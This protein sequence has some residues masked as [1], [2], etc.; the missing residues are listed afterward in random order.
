MLELIRKIIPENFFLRIWWHRLVGLMAAIKYGFPAKNLEVIGVTGTDGKS[1]TVEFLV[2]ILEEK[3]LKVGVASTIRFQVGDKKWDN[4]THKTTMGR[5]ALQKL[6]KEMKKEKC[7]VVVLEV[8]S[9]ALIQGRLIGIPFVSAVCTNL[10]PEHLD[11]HKNMK[12]YSKAKEILFNNV[13]RNK[14]KVEKGTTLVIN[15]D[16]EYMNNFLQYRADNNYSFSL[17]KKS[18]VSDLHIYSSNISLSFSKTNF[19]LNIEDKKLEISLNVLG[20]FSILNAL[21]AVSL[22]I[23]FLGELKEDNLNIIKKGLEKIQRV[24]GRMELIDTENKLGEKNKIYCMIDFGLTPKAVND[25]YKIIRK[26]VKENKIITVFGACGNRDKTKRPIIGDLAHKNT[27]L[28]VICDDETYGEDFDG[29]RA[30]IIEGA[31]E[32]RNIRTEKRQK[33]LKDLG[34][35]NYNDKI[36]EVPDRGKAIQFAISRANSGDCV[37]VSGIGDF[38]SRVMGNEKIDWDEREEIIKNLHKKFA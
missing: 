1:S 38:D 4:K 26:I 19:L 23:P 7:D 8:S 37:L 11:F 28:I 5:F 6:L 16:D 17:E 35:C 36:F 13:S 25:I 9:H 22:A 33:Q 20:D 14:T 32:G 3:G 31:L 29:I 10:S 27:D 30:D 2:S 21:A 15:I 18:F 12:S 34:V 24:P